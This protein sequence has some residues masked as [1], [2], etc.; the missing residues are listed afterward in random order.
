MLAT[1]VGAGCKVLKLGYGVVEEEKARGNEGKGR[2]KSKSA[3]EE[4]QEEQEKKEE[5]NVTKSAESY[6]LEEVAAFV[7]GEYDCFVL[8]EI[9][10]KMWLMQI[11]LRTKAA[12][13]ARTL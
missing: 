3:A 5:E 4:E 9:R 12:I 1:S 13:H 7:T 10:G 6:T 8:G 2:E 11:N